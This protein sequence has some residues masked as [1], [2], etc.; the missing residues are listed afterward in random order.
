MTKADLIDE[1]SKISSLTKKETETFVNTI[2]FQHHRGP[3]QGRQ[4]RASRLREFSH[5]TPELAQGTQSEDGNGCRRS[6]EARAVLQ[7]RKAPPGTRQHVSRHGLD[8]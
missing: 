4:G 2:F 1:I 7:G 8:G 5:P 6:A 3:R